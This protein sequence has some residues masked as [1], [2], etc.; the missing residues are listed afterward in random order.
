M[1][2]RLPSLRARQVIAALRRAGFVLIRQSGSH[3]HF[4][5]GTLTVTIPVH[6]GDLHRTVLSSI[7]RQARMTPAEFLDLL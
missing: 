4:R 7:L 5:K 6:S 2:D 1:P 3:A